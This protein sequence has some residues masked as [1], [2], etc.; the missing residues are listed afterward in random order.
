ML[1]EAQAL[2]MPGLKNHRCKRGPV[3]AEG[4]LCHVERQRNILI[5]GNK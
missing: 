4:L 3:R 1:S 5:A 2:Q